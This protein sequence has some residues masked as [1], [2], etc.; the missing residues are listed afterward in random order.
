MLRI[1]WTTSEYLKHIDV[2]ERKKAIDTIK[3]QI[4]TLNCQYS[5]LNQE[6]DKFEDAIAKPFEISVVDL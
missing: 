3:H 1:C 6:K 4:Q 5:D 2:L